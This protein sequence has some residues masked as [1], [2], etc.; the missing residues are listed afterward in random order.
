ME[1]LVQY[2]RTAVPVDH[3]PKTG[4]TVSIAVPVQYRHVRMTRTVR[5]TSE[6][7]FREPYDSRVHLYRMYMMEKV[8]VRHRYS[9]EKIPVHEHTALSQGLLGPERAENKPG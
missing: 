1:N 3:P 6:A 2:T 4:S 8:L 9:A 7:R 5:V